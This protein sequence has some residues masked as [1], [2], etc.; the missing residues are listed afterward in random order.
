MLSYYKKRSDGA[1]GY[2]KID[3]SLKNPEFR[4]TARDGYPY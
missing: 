1:H 4:V 2:Q 3:V